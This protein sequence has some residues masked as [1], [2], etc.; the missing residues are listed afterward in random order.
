MRTQRGSPAQAGFTLLELLVAIMILT[1]V[2]AVALG[3]VR[4]GNR[5]F[6]AGITRA[7]RTA[8]IRTLANV[9][10]RQL[11][12]LLPITWNENG[13]DFIAFE[14]DKHQLRFVG[15]APQSS[16]GPGYFVYSLD[17]KAL[18]GS[19]RVTLSF[20]P[21]DPGSEGFSMSG[22][23]SQELLTDQLSD[24]SFDY[25]G[26]QD[27][28][29]RPSWHAVWPSSAGRLPSIVRMQLTSSALQ[30]PDLLFQIHFEAE[31]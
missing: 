12:Q 16:T 8:E 26:A 4:V 29:E 2:L 3:A 22:I 15:P 1:L 13:Q 19:S 17:V 14:G 18:S 25:Y 9:L 11:W 27:E 24:A 5:S 6:Q 20:A 31:G 23:S 21:F 30:W 10:R 28:R 7:D